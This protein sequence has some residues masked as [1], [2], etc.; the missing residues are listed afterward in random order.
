MTLAT[1]RV[2]V[3]LV[4]AGTAI[5]PAQGAALQQ[6]A[7]AEASVASAF[8]LFGHAPDRRRAI[9]AAWVFH[10]FN[11]AGPEWISGLGIQ[12]SHWFGGTFVNSY[13]VRSLMAGV[14]RYWWRSSAGGLRF[15]A[16]YRLGLVTGYDEKLHALAGALPVMPFAGLL[17][18]TETG[19]MGL[20]VY[21]LYKAITVEM[22]VGF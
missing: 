5:G 14:E 1:R 8:R 18:W 4:L 9:G 21:Y 3:C 10:P 11:R 6:T 13:G 16:G 20:D 15:G 22:S 2:A 19:G 17:L 7:E 12:F